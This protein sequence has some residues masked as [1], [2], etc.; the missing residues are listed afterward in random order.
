[1][2]AFLRRNAA[3]LFAATYFSVVGVYDICCDNLL[4]Y[5]LAGF[6]FGVV[7]GAISFMVTEERNYRA[8]LARTR[9]KLAELER[10]H[11]AG[12]LDL[13]GEGRVS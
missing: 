1:M 2:H 11:H 10:E 8:R 6:A 5:V 4:G 9:A 12:S 13:T 7:G 3:A